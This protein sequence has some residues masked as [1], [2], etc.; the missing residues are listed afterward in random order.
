M[1]T[2]RGPAC[3]R[4]LYRFVVHTRSEEFVTIYKS[5]GASVSI[6]GYVCVLKFWQ[7]QMFGLVDYTGMGNY[8]SFVC[9]INMRVC[10]T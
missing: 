3:A 9:D 10:T 2:T 5:F 6:G 4:L 8:T 1:Y 7:L